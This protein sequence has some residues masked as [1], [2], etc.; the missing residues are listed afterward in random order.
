MLCE[1]FHMTCCSAPPKL[2]L[3]KQ[4][5]HLQIPKNTHNRLIPGCHNLRLQPQSQGYIFH[6]PWQ[7]SDSVG[8]GTHVGLEIFSQQIF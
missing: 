1:T 4:V 7:S 6:I 5:A 3:G 2:S 8:M